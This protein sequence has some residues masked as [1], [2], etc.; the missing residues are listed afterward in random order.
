[1]HS[2]SRLSLAGIIGLTF[3]APCA[4]AQVLNWT[5]AANIADIAPGGGLAATF[6]SFSQPAIDNAR[7]VVFR[8][9]STTGDSSQTDG[10]YQIDLSGPNPIVKLIARDDTVPQPNNTTYQGALAEFIEFPSTPRIDAGSGLV[11][12]TGQ[13]PSVWTYLLD[14][15]ETR[16]GTAGV[17]AF[18]GGVPVTA[19]SLLGAVVEVDQVTLSFPWYSVPGSIFGT[20]FDQ[21]PGSPAAFDGHFVSFKGNY[22]DP[23]DSLG[24]TGVYYRDVT[25]ADP[26]PYTAL[27]ANSDTIIPNQPG[28]GS[29]TFGSTAPPSAANGYVYFTGFDNEDA[30][31]LGGIYR[32]Q[33][34]AAAP[35]VQVPLPPA[36]TVIVGVG[37]Q[38]PGEPAG[39]VFNNF[40]EALSVSNDGG[41]VAFW[42]SWGTD[43]FQ[44]TLSCPTDGQS[45]LID[46]CNSQYPSGY[47][48]DVPV[49][50]G[51]FVYDASNGVI[52]RL[53]RTGEDGVEDFLYWTFSGLVPGS[54]GSTDPGAELARWRAGSF[55]ALSELADGSSQVA[56]KAQRDGTDGIY[57]REGLG[58]QLPLQ[59][60]AE[61]GTTPGM[62][63]DPL[64]PAG[65]L[66]STV[67][68]ER[69]GFRD[70]Q[71]SITVGMLY[72]DP[73]DSS[74]TVGWAGVY[75][76]AVPLDSIFHDGFD[77]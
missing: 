62:S 29:V 40:G 8:A 75:A 22:T 38:V 52:T 76:A 67:G 9:R 28:G 44:K 15:T 30:P 39:S 60:V 18:P 59:T 68:L 20:R 70:G 63:I 19:A 11:A 45:S 33:V 32:A 35:V 3:A 71:L 1:M 6:R 25:P 31:T 61:V 50:Q 53:A 12:I 48:A 41:R 66:V 74:T 37:D 27:I 58:Y 43:T 24:R 10:V 34:A 17:Y 55:A 73:N 21:F 46:Y 2:F 65:S 72:V 14:T 5:T 64:A 26:M 23:S 77:G 56:F 57:L 13:H 42:A 69:D 49:N 7:T 47:T 36:L 4:F 16:V 51:L 54:G